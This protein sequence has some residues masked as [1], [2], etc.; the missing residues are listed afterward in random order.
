MI[1]RDRLR[2]VDAARRLLK[3]QMQLAICKAKAAELGPSDRIWGPM[4]T[5]TTDFLEEAHKNW[6]TCLKSVHLPQEV[7]LLAI[8]EAL[9]QA[10]Q[11]AGLPYQAQCNPMWT[12]K[13]IRTFLAT[14]DPADLL[15][16]PGLA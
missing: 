2:V 14:F 13:V 4:L 12:Q 3:S 10:S 5:L 16:A 8:I 15:Q 1:A 7:L 9:N 6:S 11:E